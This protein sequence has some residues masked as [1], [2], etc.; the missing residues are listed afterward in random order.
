MPGSFIYFFLNTNVRKFIYV[1]NW[2]LY[3]SASVA[4]VAKAL[5]FSPSGK[6]ML[7]RLSLPPVFF[8]S[9]FFVCFRF[10]AIHLCTS[11]VLSKILF[12]IGFS[13]FHSIDFFKELI[14]FFVCFFL[15]LFPGS[16]GKTCMNVYYTFLSEY[17]GTTIFSS[18]ITGIW[19]ISMCP[20]Q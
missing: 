10:F 17:V 13:V 4:V 11:I 19:Q 9:S 7:V 6:I 3:V 18:P 15:F 14:C 1:I 20:I 12:V 16:P 5:P 8:F 2:P